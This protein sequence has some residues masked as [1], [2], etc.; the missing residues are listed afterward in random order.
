MVYM[1]NNAIFFELKKRCT[2]ISH[3]SLFFV[4]ISK[5]YSPNLVVYFRKHKVVLPSKVVE[6]PISST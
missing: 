3:F 5:Y 2:Y 6:N 4:L 1:K